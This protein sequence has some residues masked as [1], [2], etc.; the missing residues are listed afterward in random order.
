MIKKLKV[1]PLRLRTTQGCL[2]SP[3]LFNVTLEGPCVCV[4]VCAGAHTHG[5]SSC[6]VESDS[7]AQWNLA[8]QA[9]L[10]MEFSSQERWSRLLFP[11]PGDLPD[12]GI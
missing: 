10:S 6:S 7:V 3:L 1:L 4:C 12:P 11:A 8:G 2:F 5:H 9:P